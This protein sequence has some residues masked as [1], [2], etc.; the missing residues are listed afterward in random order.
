MILHYSIV[1]ENYNL[2]I[3]RHGTISKWLS[4]ELQTNKIAWST[5]SKAVLQS[6]AEL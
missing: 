2:Y 1:T 5:L 4:N 6:L 3:S